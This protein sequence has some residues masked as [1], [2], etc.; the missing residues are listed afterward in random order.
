[1]MDQK[2]VFTDKDAM[3]DALTTQKHIT[4]VYNTFECEAATPGVK[5]CLSSILAEEHRIGDELFCEMQTRGW[6]SVEK[7]EEQK[8]ATA[9]QQFS[10]VPSVN[11]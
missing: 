4:G 8:L 10:R 1:M 11:S 7:A 6:Y 9:K 3:T 5:N 2:N